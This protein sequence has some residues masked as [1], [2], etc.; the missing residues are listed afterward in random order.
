M[1]TRRSRIIDKNGKHTAVHKRLSAPLAPSSR[2]SGILPRL[3]ALSDLADDLADDWL[4]DLSGLIDLETG[5][6]GYQAFK[7]STSTPER[8]SR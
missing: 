6:P 2:T 8:S 3:S 7:P 1:S 4:P 5:N